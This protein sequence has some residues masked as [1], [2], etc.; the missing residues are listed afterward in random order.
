[1]NR[2][3]RT[4][5]IYGVLFHIVLTLTNIIF[6]NLHVFNLIRGY[7]IGLFFSKCGKKISIASGC[8]FNAPWN[9]VVGDNVYFAHRC[10]VNA[11]GGIFVGN[12][13]IVSPNVVIATTSH[14]R[15]DNKVSLR[16]SNLSPIEIKSGAWIA[17]NSVVTKGATIGMGAVIGANSVVLG[18]IPDNCFYAGN[19]AI[20]I[21]VL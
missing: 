21:R 12:E 4:F 20:F 5:F 6:P 9:M 18:I 11:S 3:F 13:V 8:I 2:R 19:P 16:S 17:S 15:V 1:M 14:A 10:W 7:F